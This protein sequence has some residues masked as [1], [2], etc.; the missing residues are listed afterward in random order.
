MTEVQSP[1]LGKSRLHISRRLAMFA[2]TFSLAG[3]DYTTYIGDSFSHHVA[4]ITT[5]GNGNT[6]VTGSRAVTSSLTDVFVSKIDLS[7]NVTLVAT[8]SGKGSDE[9]HAIALDPSGNIYVA[10]S[11]TSPDFSA[12]SSSAKRSIFQARL[13]YNRL[14]GE[15]ARTASQVQIASQT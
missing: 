7:G 15:D 12:A 6:Y 13:R 8:L 2:C 9:A 4:A 1:H 5:D 11:T 3:A 14:S 10:G